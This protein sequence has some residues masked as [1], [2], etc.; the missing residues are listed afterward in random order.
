MK[1]FWVFLNRRLSK[2][3]QTISTDSAPHTE[4]TF[5]PMTIWSRACQ[6]VF[7]DVNSKMWP[8]CS[9]LMSST[10]LQVFAQTTQD[11]FHKCAVSNYEVLEFV[12]VYQFEFAC[13][14][15]WQSSLLGP[16]GSIKILCPRS[17]RQLCIQLQFPSLDVV[18]HAR[19]PRSVLRCALWL[20]MNWRH[21]MTVSSD[22][23]RKYSTSNRLSWSG[24][25][26]P[27]CGRCLLVLLNHFLP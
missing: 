7:S 3:N 26:L 4:L 20:A 25:L 5:L 21:S 8:M 6:N 1:L 19:N 10:A 2:R 15:M 17:C 24:S 18:Q 16:V 13:H 22:R 9:H 14:M 11:N 12:R 27:K 23:R